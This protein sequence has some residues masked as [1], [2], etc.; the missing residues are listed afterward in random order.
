MLF[1]GG[2]SCLQQT[3]LTPSATCEKDEGTATR[4]TAYWL[5]LISRTSAN[6]WSTTSPNVRL[7]TAASVNIWSIISPNARL[8]TAPLTPPRFVRSKEEI[9]ALAEASKPKDTVGEP[10]LS[11]GGVLYIIGV[12]RPATFERKMP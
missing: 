3:A 12:R 4:F 11:Y 10:I 6:V 5:P 2:L 9:S 7:Y 8:C 1:E